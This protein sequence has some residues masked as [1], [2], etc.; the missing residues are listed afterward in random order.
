[1]LITGWGQKQMSLSPVGTALEPWIRALGHDSQQDLLDLLEIGQEEAFKLAA[2][3]GIGRQVLEL[4]QGQGQMAL[5]DLLAQRLRSPEEA[6]GQLFDLPCTELLST[7]GRD[8]GIDGRC[9][10]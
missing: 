6:V 2:S 9:T 8:E 10:V 1:M 4:L 5:E 3:V 7:Q